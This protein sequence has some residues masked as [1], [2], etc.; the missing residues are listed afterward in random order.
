MNDDASGRDPRRTE[1]PA[2][3]EPVRSAPGGDI[4]ALGALDLAAAYSELRLSPVE[5]T[6]ALL[7]RIDA[8]EPALNAMVHLDRDGALAAARAA[9]ARWHLGT[10]LS[11]LDGVPVTIKDMPDV[12]GW[13]TVAGSRA[14][15]PRTPAEDAPAVA[16]L[17]E[18]GAVLLG[19]TAVPEFGCKII[20]ES[21]AHGVTRNPWSLAHTPG[22][23]S[24]GAAAGLA[25]G[26]APL[27]LGTDGA[28]SLRIPASHTATLALKPSVGRVSVFPPDPDAPNAVTGPMARSAADLTAMLSVIAQPDAR[29]PYA[30]PVPF[31]PLPDA[32]V[33]GVRVAFS[34]TLGLAAPLRNAEVDAL[35]ARAVPALEAAGARVEWADPHWPL[36]PLAPF[37]VFWRVYCNDLA[38]AADPGRRH[39]LDPIIAAEAALG[40]AIDR[41]AYRAAMAQRVALAAAARAFHRCFDILVGPVVPVPPTLA[42]QPTPDG[43]APDD[44]SWCPFTYPFNMTGQPA[45]AVPAGFTRAGLPVGVQIIGRVG[46]DAGVLRVAAVL[47]SGPRGAVRPNG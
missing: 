20:C 22:G 9:E 11:P 15:A 37:L 29:D 26:Y 17:R 28:G 12:A 10:P 43:Y 13:P 18:A 3:A 41:A 34:P 33:N 38:R 23:S 45:G 2:L 35:V 7:A 40:A 4:A 31:A 30:W 46:H 36:D 6:Q 1:T 24:G 39:A 14:I 27:A 8:L 42:D 47:E 19:K 21:P 44:W 5:A 16:R 32:H 25:A